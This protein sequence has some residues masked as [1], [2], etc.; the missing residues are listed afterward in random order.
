MEK[1]KLGLMSP[2]TWGRNILKSIEKSDK[3]KII[4][5]ASRNKQSAEMAGKDFNLKVANSYNELLKEDIS[6]VVLPTPHHLHYEQTLM[7][8]EAGKHVF[9]EKPIANT[10]QEAKGMELSCEKAG[11]ILMVGHLQRRLP[12]CRTAKRMISSGEYGLPINAI[13]YAGLQGV[14]MYGLGHWLL[15]GKLN[16]GGSLYM[17]GVH[18]TETLQYIMGPVKTISGF[19]VRNFAGTTIPEVA[20]GI[21]EFEKKR[22]GYLGSHYIAPYNSFITIYCQNGIFYIEK[23]GRELYFQDSHFPKI[24]KKEFKLDPT[25]CENP[26]QEELEEFADCINGIRKPETGAK[27]AIAAL[28]AIR[29]MM[30]SAKEKRTVTLEEI[31]E[32]Y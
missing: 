27:E 11:V 15:D 28:A 25:P 19:E 12:G 16:P 6:G 7:A 1:I 20:A 9:V 8:A 14:E 32:K 23:F 13:A 31:I 10:I 29:G 2:G 5:C 3:V 26:I 22:L 18:F 30:I 24:E 4:V 17:M 21:F